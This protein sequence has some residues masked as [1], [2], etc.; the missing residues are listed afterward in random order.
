MA[1]A[2][3]SGACNS[4]TVS[5]FVCLKSNKQMPQDVHMSALSEL[6]PTER[7]RGQGYTYS[8]VVQTVINRPGLILARQFVSVADVSFTLR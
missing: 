1:V 3:S 5:S 2:P 7:I 8:H 6:K 4:A